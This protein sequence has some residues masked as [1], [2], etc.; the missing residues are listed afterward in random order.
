MDLI[1]INEAIHD[2]YEMKNILENTSNSIESTPICF[3][4]CESFKDYD[5]LSKTE[6]NFNSLKTIKNES[7]IIYSC[8]MNNSKFTALKTHFNTLFTITYPDDFFEKIQNNTF[9]TIIGSTINFDLFCFAVL[10]INNNKKTAEILS[11]GVIK[12]YQA[13]KYGTRLMQKIIEEMKILAI[14]E[15]T[16]IVQVTNKIAINLYEKFGFKIVKEEPDYYHILQGDHRKAY[17]MKK[18]II[19]EQF[20]FF[21]IFNNIAK[22]FYIYK[23]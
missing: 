22:K 2:D 13:K 19:S 5:F 21:K 3:S 23:E 17:I 16:L 15:I 20:W 12:E 9:N 1:Q 4:K 6:D 14:K 10:D 11:F 8:K 18:L 7:D